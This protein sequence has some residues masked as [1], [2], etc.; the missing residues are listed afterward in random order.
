MY[1]PTIRKLTR[2][3]DHGKRAHI[4]VFFTAELLGGNNGNSRC[5][6]IKPEHV[7]GFEGDEAWF[8]LERV[9]AKPWSY[10]R[11]VRQVQPPEN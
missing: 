8:E 9:R 1:A 5:T 3:R 10:W 4:T 11:A 7:P 2:V 6:F